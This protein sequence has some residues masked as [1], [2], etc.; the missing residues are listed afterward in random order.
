MGL[1]IG[2][3][4]V[5]LTAI[6]VA[7]SAAGTARS[8]VEIT[9]I[10]F[11]PISEG[12]W[13]WVEV[14]N[15]TA[16]AV[17][18]D[19]W[20]LDDDDDSSISMPNI[21]STH[22]NTTVPAGGIAVLYNGTDLNFDPERF[23]NAWGSGMT[24][25]PV[26][27]LTT[28]STSDAI[29]LWNSH[30]NYAGDALPSSTSPRRTFNTAVTSINYDTANGF[31]PTTN[32]H[33]IAWKGAGNS[34]TGANW[35]SSANGGAGAHVSVQT[36]I[37]GAPLNSVDDRGTPGAVPGGGAADGLVISEIMYDPASTPES[38]WEWI[39][40]FNNTGA[41]IDFST[42]KYVLDDDDEASLNA[43]NVTAGSIP[44]GATGVLYNAAGA[45]LENMKAAWGE[46]VNFIP[47]TS[48]ADLT[49]TGG[50]TIAIWSS[51]T[52]YQD[53]TQLPTAPRRT[54][55]NALSVVKYLNSAA[56]G[57][58]TGND[59]GSIFM[60]NLTAAQSD[61]SSWLRSNATNSGPPQQVSGEA[62][63]HPGGDVGSPG[64]VPGVVTPA[65]N[66]DYNGNG[67]VDAADYTLWRHAM[68]RGGTLP[69]DSTP[70]SVT[71]ADYDV[72]RANF[73]KSSGAGSGID[74]NSV[75][76]PA[77]APSIIAMLIV[78]MTFSRRPM[79]GR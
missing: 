11:D 22:G 46:N 55:N 2:P 47:V 34:A 1:R 43:E 69:H 10:M 52:A 6:T 77:S 72:W 32:G 41:L 17:N 45:S 39:E 35:V 4:A 19:N 21:S 18:L 60:P 20:V 27:G 36:T 78:C 13:E 57:W 50:D 76:E 8:Q 71:N 75:P 74:G 42:T 56:A 14:R 28:L 24:L 7:F 49:N 51:L 38:D 62:V 66:G 68:Q 54:T 25:I 59:S 63:D 5:G 70:G 37:A 15:T 40:V 79:A 61:G 26:S 67:R 30:A 31:P 58:P 23:T 48:W 29:G 33:S 44:Q 9:E 3:W 16:D 12:A 53:E 73:G 64:F 65:L